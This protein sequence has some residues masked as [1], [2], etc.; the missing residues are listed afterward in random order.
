ML[1][2]IIKYCFSIILI[3]LLIYLLKNNSNQALNL[4]TGNKFSQI[5][6]NIDT[7]SQ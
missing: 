4:K 7:F 1:S 3:I 6:N 2:N 5:N